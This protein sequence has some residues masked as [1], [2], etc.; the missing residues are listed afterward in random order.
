M[1]FDYFRFHLIRKK[2]CKILKLYVI[3]M[4]KSRKYFESL[5]TFFN[6]TSLFN[7]K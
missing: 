4:K 3:E 1:N 6:N 7:S 2:F 5:K